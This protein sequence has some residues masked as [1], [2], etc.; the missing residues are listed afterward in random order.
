MEAS[1]KQLMRLATPALP[2]PPLPTP[3]PANE[4]SMK[5]VNNYECKE[6]NG[7]TTGAASLKSGTHKWIEQD[8]T[9][10]R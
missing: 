10:S 9:K 6:V 4:G 3:Q 5:G 2:L 1:A 8:F 7:G